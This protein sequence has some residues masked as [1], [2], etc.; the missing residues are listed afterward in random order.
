MHARRLERPDVAPRRPKGGVGGERSAAMGG[1]RGRVFPEACVVR[2][3]D[4][5]KVAAK[6]LFNHGTLQ[7][8][9][10]TAYK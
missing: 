2:T 8:G 7:S 3:M 6:Y 9:M 5:Q 10:V 4:M 1:G